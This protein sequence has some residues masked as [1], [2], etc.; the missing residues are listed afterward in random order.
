MA[1]NNNNN[2]TGKKSFVAGAA[3]LGVAGLITKL[4]GAVFRIPLANIIGAS[5]MAYYQTAYP[6][7][8]MLLMVSTTGLPTAI[9]RMVAERRAVGQYYEA[10]RVFKISFK[11]MLALGLVTGIGL[12]VLAPAICRFQMEPDAVYA[13]RA[14]AP[15]LILCPMMS[16]FRGFF[17]GRKTMTP[18]AVSQIAEQFFR[19]GLGLFL[20]YLLLKIDA[21][22]AAAGASF[23]AT[24]G[25]LFG[26]IAVYIVYLKKKN[27]IVGEFTDKTPVKTTKEIFKEI[28]IIA[29]PITIGAGIMPIMNWIDTLVV[30]RRLLAIGY[31]NE[32]A[33]TMF[34]E[35]SGLAAPIINFPNV[36]T[37]AVCM[38]L[39]PVITDA[40][41]RED[42]DFIRENASLSLR[43]SA[44]IIMPCAA[45]LVTLAQ[46]IMKLL[47]PRQLESAVAAAPCLAI[48]AV[49]MIFLSTTQATNG[50]LQGIGKQMIPVTSLLAGAIVKFIATFTLTGIPSLNVKGAAFGS[51]LANLTAATCN[52]I[53]VKRFTG[54]KIDWIL[55]CIKPLA[56]SVVMAGFVLGAFKVASLKFGNT[57]STFIGIMVGVVIYVLMVFI[58]KTITFAEL[59]KMLKRGK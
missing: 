47:Y 33:R 32:V 45:G 43:Y 51:L 19:V 54:F 23:G 39:V 9:S 12:F 10:H 52:L 41:K 14:T 22:H 50:V 15:A 53:A 34:G 38:S 3:I 26:F 16:C 30:K 56:S 37:S 18:T 48:Y 2:N 4:L 1:E 7:Y 58:T 44:I 57:I 27:E 24:A 40:F 42:H 25:A 21:P 36:F 46:P 11:L 55:S 28:L 8:V 59:K 6:V 13:M 17:Q 31:S 5:G 29:V 49:G 20:A 35:L